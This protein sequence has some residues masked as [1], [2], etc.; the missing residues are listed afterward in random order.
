M[1]LEKQDMID[2]LRQRVEEKLEFKV[3]FQELKQDLQCVSVRFADL[4]KEVA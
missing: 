1:N 2:S 4:R 3:K